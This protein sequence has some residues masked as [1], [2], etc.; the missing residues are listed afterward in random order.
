MENSQPTN[1]IDA[2]TQFLTVHNTT[3]I[4]I[5]MTIAGLLGQ[6]AQE[7]KEAVYDDVEDIQ[8]RM[9]GGIT[10]EERSLIDAEMADLAE[11]TGESYA[12]ADQIDFEKVKDEVDQKENMS[13]YASTVLQISVLLSSVGMTNKAK[14]LTYLASGLTLIGVLIEIFMAVM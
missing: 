8:D 3:I 10:D 12:S 7:E 2:F 5:I 11:E 1:K 13:G 6:H 14:L 4:A 9:E